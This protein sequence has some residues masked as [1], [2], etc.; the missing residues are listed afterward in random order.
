MKI[1]HYG[2]IALTALFLSGCSQQILQRTEA[3]LPLV[4]QWNELALAGIREEPA[5]RAPAVSRQLFLLHA[6][7]YDAWTAFDDQA[8]PY[9]MPPIKLAATLRTESNQRNAISQAA[10]RVLQQR[11]GRLSGGDFKPRLRRQMARYG[12]NIATAADSTTAAGIGYLAA[13]SVLQKQADDGANEARLYSEITSPTYPRRYA[14]VN[15]AD[16][17]SD[18]APGGAH[19]DPN[20]WQPLQ[21]PYPHT[22]T[23]DGRKQYDPDRRSDYDI[24]VF[25][26]PHWGA[27]R[28]FALASGAQL[29]P[30]PPPQ[31][32]SS[33]PY[34]D[35]KGQRMSNDQAY[36]AQVAQILQLNASLT[37]RDKAIAEFWADGPRS[38]SPPGHWNQLAHGVS[39]RDSHTLAADVKFFFALNAALFDA[40]IAAWD[41]K[42]YYDY[43]RPISAI[44]YLYR[45]QRIRGWGGINQGIIELP[46]EDWLPYQQV[47]F[48]TPPFPEYVSGHSTFSSAAAE[49]LQRFT[50][51]DRF[52]DG[53]SRSGQDIDND[54]E[55]D[56]LGRYVYRKNSAFFERGPSQDIVLEWPTFTAAA[57]EAAYSR[58]IGGIHFQDG[59]LRGR[60]LG[61]EVGALAFER[62]RNLWLGQ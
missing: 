5:I 50:G 34:T 41:A 53:V 23:V 15:D 35:G 45:G 2:W 54:G 47:T 32:G 46:G 6:A 8:R 30:P 38:E 29:R 59:D 17:R 39:S 33:T 24:Q 55:D 57:N 12:F 61:R 3:A 21:V 44:R 26:T 7:M 51:S 36:R 52:F 60:V 4:V 13:E 48:I 49:V 58:L 1:A 16:W 56:L 37:E 22:A 9:A 62:A 25:M 40:S 42:R 19:F 28:P 31:F 43:V 10:Y 14:A 18:G 20:R 11:F 27:V